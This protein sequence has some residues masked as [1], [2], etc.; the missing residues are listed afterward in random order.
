MLDELLA[1]L[2]QRSFATQADAER[3]VA[4]RMRDYNSRP[5]PELGGL[6]PNQM[7]ALLA[8]DW[9]ATGSFRVVATLGGGEIGDPD[10]L[11]NAVGFLTLLRDDGPAKATAT[12]SL[13]R[14]AVSRL[15]TRLRFEEGYLDEVRRMNKVI[16][17]GDVFPVE[18]LRHVLEFARLIVR[19]KGF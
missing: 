2:N 15:L 12:G 7:S 6:S 13:S 4:A 14:D 5:Q 9:D 18:I 19:R 17:E 1:E 8:G 10:F 16:N 3:F 11:H